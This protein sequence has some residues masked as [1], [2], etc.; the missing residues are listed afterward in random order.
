MG[1]C[2][3]ADRAKIRLDNQGFNGKVIRVEKAIPQDLNKV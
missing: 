3:E 2:A 1:S